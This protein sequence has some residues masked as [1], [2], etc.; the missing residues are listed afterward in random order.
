MSGLLTKVEYQAIAADLEL[1]R[2]ALIDRKFVPARSGDTFDC[3]I[4]TPFG[5]YKQSGFGGRDDSLLAHDQY[6]E[7]KT[8]WFEPSDNDL[9]AELV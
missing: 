7:T 1:P 5:G 4:S 3:W 8:I 2:N 9:V 6:T